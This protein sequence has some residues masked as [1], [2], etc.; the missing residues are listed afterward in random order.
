MIQ[1][2]FVAHPDLNYLLEL[3]VTG[4]FNSSIFGTRN[5]GKEDI[6]LVCGE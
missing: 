6:G 5:C 2:I 3:L 4:A 1:S